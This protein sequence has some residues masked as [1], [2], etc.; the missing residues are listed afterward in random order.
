MK[1]LFLI[2]PFVIGCSTVSQH[3]SQISTLEEQNTELR[4]QVEES[5]KQNSISSH[6]GALDDMPKYAS[7]GQ[8]F[9]KVITPAKYSYTNR[10]MMVSPEK[11]QLRSKAA[12]YRYVN[13]KVVVEQASE[14]V[15]PVPATYKW[16]ND[17]I[18]VRDAATRLV[19]IP[20]RYKTVSNRVLVSPEREVWKRGEPTDVNENGVLCKVKIPAKYKTVTKKVLVSEA[21]T[22][23][24]EIPATYQ[25]L[26][27]RV[28]ATPATH[29]TVVIPAVT[30]VIKTREL[31]NAAET[32]TVKSPAKFRTIRERK[33]VSEPKVSW[34]PILCQTNATASSV[35]KVQKALQLSGYNPGRIDGVLGKDTARAIKSFQSKKN[36]TQGGLTLETLKALNVKL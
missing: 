7:A 12:Q 10:S 17:R 11:T 24:K 32:F 5:R 18:K 9:T 6:T 14:R 21:R 29:R 22:I 8:C 34:T 23:E 35:V 3:R 28:I 26:K 33:M 20:E 30:K 1:S 16:V 2:L 27:R 4:Q 31:V 15:I 36:L 19:Q 25:T 13:K